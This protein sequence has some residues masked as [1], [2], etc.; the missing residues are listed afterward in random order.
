MFHVNAFYFYA[1]LQTASLTISINK[2]EFLFKATIKIPISFPLSDM[3]P[4]HCTCF[5]EGVFVSVIK[6]L[7]LLSGYKFQFVFKIVIPILHICIS[8]FQSNWYL[9]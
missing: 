4:I 9:Q 5:M 1:S 6:F 3:Y 2:I 7:F 8:V